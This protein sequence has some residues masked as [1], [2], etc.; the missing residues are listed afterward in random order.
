MC[1]EVLFYIE[2]LT[3]LINKI[4]ESQESDNALRQEQYIGGLC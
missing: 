1:L 2:T 4:E 3:K